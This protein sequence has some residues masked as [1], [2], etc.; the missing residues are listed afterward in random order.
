MG[1]K[2]LTKFKLIGLD[3]NIF[4][5]YFEQHPIFGSLTKQIFNQLADKKIKAITSTITIIELLSQ[6][7]S[8]EKISILKESLLT[9]SSLEIIEV[10]T[11]IGIEAARIRREYGYRLP[12]S[13]QLATALSSRAKVFITNDSRLKGFKKL[14]VMTLKEI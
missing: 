5:Y 14:K 3:T 13:I 6:K 8:P 10:T 2:A 11:K 4:I 12:D 9:M 1:K 7:S